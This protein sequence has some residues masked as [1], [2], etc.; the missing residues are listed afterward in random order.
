[1]IKD[2]RGRFAVRPGFEPGLDGPKPPVLPL[3][4]RTESVANLIKG[5]QKQTGFRKKIEKTTHCKVINPIPYE[6]NHY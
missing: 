6:R 2:E 4:H 1:M 3:H 5:F